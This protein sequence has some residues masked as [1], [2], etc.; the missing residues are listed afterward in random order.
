MPNEATSAPRIPHATSIHTSDPYDARMRTQQLLQCSHRMTVL[1]REHPF[2]ARIQ[3]RTI[4]GMGLMSSTYG[5]RVEIGCSPPIELVTV[6]FVFGGRMLVEDRGRTTVADDKHGAV[7]CFYDDV[8]MSWTPGLAQLMLTIE[9]PLVERHLRNLLHDPVDEPVRFAAEVDLTGPGQSLVAA[10]FTLRR[11]LESCGKAGPPPVL[12]A[13]IEHGILNALLLGQPHNYTDAIFSPR[14]L[15]APRVV[16]RV[17]DL[18]DST[19]EKSFTVADLAEFAGVSERSLH[20]AFRRELGT[21]PMSYVRHRRLDQAR[22]ELLQLGP[23]AGTNVTDI[24]LRYGFAHTGRFAAAYRERF[25][26][27][28][29]T[30]L[31]RCR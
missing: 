9:K 21:S 12:A 25:G 24:A 4:R 22:D 10:V 13:E 31:R 26:E 18:I 3:H 11:A 23:A 28:P 16:R 7:F 8:D 6:N 17:I 19:P 1:D 20:A 5:P 15:P 29:S 30:T 2:L 27:P 14:A